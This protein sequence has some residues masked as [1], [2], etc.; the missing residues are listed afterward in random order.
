MESPILESNEVPT[1]SSSTR[2]IVFSV[3][4]ALVILVGA[5][6]V[7]VLFL[8]YKE[9][10]NSPK[11]IEGAH[12]NSA[13]AANYTLTADQAEAVSKYGY[14]DSFTITFYKE[15]FAPDFTGEVREEI[16]RYYKAGIARSYYEGILVNEEPIPDP[17]ASWVP[18][19][20]HPDQFTTYAPLESV[21][22]S[23]SIKDYFELPLEK[24]LIENGTLY[25]APGLAFGIVDDRLVYVETIMMQEEGE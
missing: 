24:E 5:C 2:K 23:A 19:P 21:L 20:Y 13:A 15:E 10:L 14:P 12:I 11:L 16:W 1:K 7:F 22:A 4:V 8:S 6:L 3:L 25:Y 17:P 9:Y 18:L